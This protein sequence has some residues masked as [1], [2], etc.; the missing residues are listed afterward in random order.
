MKE[1]LV[2]SMKRLVLSFSIVLVLSLG[3]CAQSETPK[4]NHFAADGVS[5]DYPDAYTVKDESNTEA[6]RLT[7]TRRGSSVQLTI[8]VT[9]EHVL[10]DQLPAAIANSTQPLIKQVAESLG[11]G[12]TPPERTTIKTM[13][14]AKEAE[15]VRL[16]ASGNS[17]R[18]A[19][20]IWLRLGLRLTSVAF[21]R[22][23]KDESP[24][25][26]LW[27]TMRSSL[28]VE[29]PVVMGVKTVAEPARDSTHEPITGGVLNGKALALPQ[30][31][32]PPIARAAHVSGTVIVQ[33]VIDEQGNVVAAKA[34]EG[35]PLLQAA[36]V[37]AAREAKFSPTTLEGEPVKVT[38]VIQYNFVAR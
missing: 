31:A 27:Q 24:G 32:Y 14:G 18:T 10:R 2:N 4:L 28:K 34:V 12:K 6:Q 30:P 13:V 38:G 17:K 36:C 8:V 16:R 21:V 9:R 22:S 29:S 23:D 7:L 5:F 1:R 3:V 11:E 35:H 26:E 37:T 19:E 15:G 20:V 25:S 33:V